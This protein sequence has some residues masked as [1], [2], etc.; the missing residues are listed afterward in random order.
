M[1]GKDE[2]TK[3]GSLKES[4]DDGTSHAEPIR[5]SPLAAREED[6]QDGTMGL[7]QR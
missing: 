5:N 1:K 7:V 2:G 4:A 3:A 6:S